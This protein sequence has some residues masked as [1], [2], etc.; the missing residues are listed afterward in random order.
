MNISKS[1]PFLFLVIAIAMLYIP[2][3]GCFP[4]SYTTASSGKQQPPLEHKTITY[5]DGS[6]YEGYVLDGRPHGNGMM[7]YPDG[8]TFIG[9]FRLGKPEGIGTMRYPDGH[10]EKGKWGTDQQFHKM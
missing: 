2:G 5:P 9:V 7:T 3:A 4:P 6:R 8:R 10:S 1:L